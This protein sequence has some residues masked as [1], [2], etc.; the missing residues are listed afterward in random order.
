MMLSGQPT[1]LPCTR[2]SGSAHRG[3]SVVAAAAKGDKASNRIGLTAANAC[4]NFWREA[5]GTAMHR[6]GEHARCWQ[7]WS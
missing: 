2:R 6:A 3:Q 5:K 7:R 4:R 1:C